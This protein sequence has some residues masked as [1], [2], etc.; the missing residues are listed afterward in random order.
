VSAARSGV[1][2]VREAPRVAELAV[3]TLTLAAL[4]CLVAVPTGVAVALALER[5]RVPGRTALRMLVIVGLVVPLPV[6]AVAW[7]V[8]L[9]AWLPSLAIEPGAVAWRPWS[10]GLLPAA[11]VHGMAGLP[12]VVWVTS[13][14]LRA[15]DRG[16]EEDALLTGGPATVF[17][18]V[19]LPR[20]ALAAVA[21]AGWVA[22][23]AATEIPVTDAMMVRTFA[24]EVYTQFAS[25]S[26]GWAGAVAV[27][28][29]AWLAAV[30]VGG[31]VAR[32]A[33]RAF[34]APP[35]EAGRPVELRLGP[36]PR[37]AIAVGVWVVVGLFAGLPL[38]ALVW[39]AG[40]GATPAG[41][42]AAEFIA[43]LRKV[44]RADGRVLLGSA[45]TALVSGAVAAGLAW[46]A[47]RPAGGSRW[48]ARGLFVLCVV[49]AV[50]PGP[51]VGYGLK[52]AI[53][54]LVGAEEW[55][56]ARVGVR[57]TF[58]SCCGRP[59]ARSRRTCWRRRGSTGWAGAAS[60]DSWSCR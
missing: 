55:V 56:L 18:R 51:V 30:L 32:R 2:P 60:G 11:W 12:W 52:E 27:T 49:L 21:S 48:L 42:G 50:T 16:L 1:A 45:G 54:Q 34:D 47:C 44:V 25:V 24:E 37:W 20:A 26:D 6:Y 36:R 4:A 3:T 15:A 58:P 19:L 59:S 23:Q 17:R 41:W 8:V 33:A 46:A 43:E 9:G 7:Q 22:V 57:P 10:L 28:L 53:R 13:A 29:P 40:G 35:A 14:G 5:V 31:W 39:K 38:A